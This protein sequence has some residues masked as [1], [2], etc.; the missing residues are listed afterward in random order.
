[1]RSDYIARAKKFV[2]F[3]E[4]LIENAE[5]KWTIKQ[6]VDAF[7]Y[8]K[9]RKVI[10]SYGLT[11]YAFITSDYVIKIDYDEDA[12]ADFGGCESEIELYEQAEQDNME[13]L[14]AKITPYYYNGRNYYIMPRIS[15][16]GRTDWNA[17]HYMTPKE[18]RW[19]DWHGVEDLHFN[20]Y[21]WRNR[22]ICII[23]YGAHD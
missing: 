20:N 17:E 11:R 9:K 7:N 6:R 1:M 10:F 22:H 2:P 23:D 19:C 8:T 4:T 13:Y 16:I 21:G 18:R 12:I 3:V 14:F 15:G 5:N